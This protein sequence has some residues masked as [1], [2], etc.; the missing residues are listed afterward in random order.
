M[1]TLG[2]IDSVGQA[3]VGIGMLFTS[4]LGMGL[5]YLGFVGGKEIYNKVLGSRGGSRKSAR[6]S[7]PSASLIIPGWDQA[8]YN[9]TRKSLE[10]AGVLKKDPFAAARAAH[11]GKKT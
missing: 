7:G 9:E 10:D 6:Q 1:K 4:I 5:L 2:E 11:P 8:A 3:P